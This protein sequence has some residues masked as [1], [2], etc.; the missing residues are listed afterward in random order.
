MFLVLLHCL[1]P[2]L[3]LGFLLELL[4]TPAQLVNEVSVVGLNALDIIL[5]LLL[6]RTL[7]DPHA[8]KIVQKGLKFGVMSKG[9]KHIISA[10]LHFLAS[11]SD[12][13]AV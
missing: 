7:P 13:D 6:H 5:D 1:F 8:P 4:D 9:A 11:L 2:S 12:Q 10:L 3:L